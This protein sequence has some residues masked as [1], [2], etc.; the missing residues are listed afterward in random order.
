MIT[1]TTTMSNFDTIF[2]YLGSDNNNVMIQY[3]NKY[4]DYYYQECLQYRYCHYYDHHYP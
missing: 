3:N 2:N 4:Y 1:I